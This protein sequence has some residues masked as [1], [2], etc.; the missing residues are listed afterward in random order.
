MSHRGLLI[1]TNVSLPTVP[2]SWH[3]FR[4]AT[5][6]E[7]LSR[8]RGGAPGA[9]RIAGSSS[10]ADL[11]GSR[12]PHLPWAPPGP[13]GLLCRCCGH[14]VSSSGVYY[15]AQSVHRVRA[16]G[17]ALQARTICSMTRAG[18]GRVRWSRTYTHLATQT[19]PCPMDS[20]RGPESQSA[21]HRGRQRGTFPAVP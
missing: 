1:Q 13:A 4:C 8:A 17:A 20:R 14:T 7:R 2:S 15:G 3:P 6:P 10:K 5:M 18:R 19:T 12:R 16:C 11:L 21:E 9:R